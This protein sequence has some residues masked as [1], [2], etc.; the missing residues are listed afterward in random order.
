MAVQSAKKVVPALLNAMS[1]ENE[2]VRKAA[3]LAYE[4]F[5]KPG[6]PDP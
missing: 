2:R 4:T 6:K 1:D 5:K 3:S